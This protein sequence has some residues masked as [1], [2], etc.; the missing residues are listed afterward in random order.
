MRS[1]RSGGAVLALMMGL[2]VLPA[3]YA[4]ASVRCEDGTTSEAGRGAC[5]HH[6]GV[7]AKQRAERERAPKAR[8]APPRAAT[9]RCEDGTRSE[10]GQGACSHHGGVAQRSDGVGGVRCEDG[11]LSASTGRGA[12]SGH[13]GVATRA[14]PEK[15]GFRWP[16]QRDEEP[17]TGGSGKAGQGRPIAK[18]RDGSVSFSRQHEGTCSHHGGV[19]RW[20]D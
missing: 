16:W 6:G 18:C 17:A 13:G 7:A 15:K 10:P 12:C 3:A 2:S 11:T 5:S 20:L 4:G 19:Q 1:L 9:V 8:K 14:E